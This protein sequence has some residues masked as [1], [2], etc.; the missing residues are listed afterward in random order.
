MSSA[1]PVEVI[2][3]GIAVNA[4]VDV[5]GAW[6]VSDKDAEKLLGLKNVR[7]HVAKLKDQNSVG[8]LWIERLGKRHWTESGVTKLAQLSRT[9]RSTA[10]LEDRGIVPRHRTRVESQ[11]SDVLLSAFR[12]LTQIDTQR[13][14]GPY[15]VDLFFP[16]FNLAIEIDENG[17]GGY[18]QSNEIIRQ[19]LL[20]TSQGCEFIRFNPDDPGK[21]V[22]DLIN[23]I[24][25]YMKKKKDRTNGGAA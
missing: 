17:H 10:F 22:G 9:A 18:R 20:E 2:I 6:A 19:I 15:R 25:R 14:F 12:D 24:L 4:Y 16:E 23:S 8:I 5:D 3:A 7:K 13:R 11:V 1:S 21:N